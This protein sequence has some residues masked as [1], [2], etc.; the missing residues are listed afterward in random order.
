LILLQKTKTHKMI[1]ITMIV[2]KKNTNIAKG[3]DIE[4]D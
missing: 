4:V 2:E 1:E 3:K